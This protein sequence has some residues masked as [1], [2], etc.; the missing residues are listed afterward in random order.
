MSNPALFD[1]ANLY[2]LPYQAKH[3][4]IPHSLFDHFHEF[5]KLR[6]VPCVKSFILW[7][8]NVLAKHSQ[9]S[10]FGNVYQLT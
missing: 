10:D 2:P 5:G 8:H 1:D 3:A 7:L 6:T 4:S 9:F